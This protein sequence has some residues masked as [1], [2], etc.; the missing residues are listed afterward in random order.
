M[1]DMRNPVK[2]VYRA[3]DGLVT[4]ADAMVVEYYDCIRPVW[5]NILQVVVHEKMLRNFFDMSM[6]D[7]MND[8][9]LYEWYVN[10]VYRNPF[11]NI[12]ISKDIPVEEQEKCCNSI[13]WEFTKFKEFYQFPHFLNLEKVLK[14]LVGNAASMVKHIYVYTG[15][16][17]NNFI[18][19]QVSYQLK[20]KTID[21][22]YG[23]FGESIQYLSKNTT[24][25]LSDYSKLHVLEEQNRIQTATVLLSDGWRYNCTRED[26]KKPIV[27]IQALRDKYTCYIEYF[28][29][30]YQEF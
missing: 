29:N 2:K 13:L 27:D 12:P 28:N 5:F 7:S 4:S 26:S 21:F 25:I 20:P 8:G 18:E 30:L 19:E 14:N 6:F 9:E 24:Y 1:S 3:I 16:Q 23:D 15:P 22:L 11:L 10:R 17:R